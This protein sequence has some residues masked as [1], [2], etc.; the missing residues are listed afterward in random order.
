M[1]FS[2]PPEDDIDWA[3]VSPA[4]AL[5]FIQRAWR[6]AGDV[7]SDVGAD[8]ANGDRALR[9][10]THKTIRE[11]T[12]HVEAFKFNV[13]VARLM[14]LTSAV[15][16]AIDSGCGPADP[17][18]RE[19]VESLAVMLSLVTP[20]TAEDMWERLGHEPTVALAG[21]PSYDADLAAA[22]SVTAVVQVAGKLRDRFEVSP[23]VS[24]DEL[25]ERALASEKVQAVLGGRDI[26]KV[27]VRV[28]KLVN[29]VPG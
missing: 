14:E 24:E 6:L 20:Y 19:A 18:V 29:I 4:G 12:D 27:I 10:V 26:R 25:R 7:S 16:K 23:D 22:E 13:G 5:R 28:P 3:D 17:A 11:V 15:R 8:A 2:G 9:K 1:V 21:W